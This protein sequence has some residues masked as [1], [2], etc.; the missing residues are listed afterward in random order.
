[1]EIQSLRS[2]QTMNI[3]NSKATNQQNVTRRMNSQ[4]NR[5]S[6]F[7]N[8][9]SSQGGFSLNHNSNFAASMKN[10]VGQNSNNSGTKPTMKGI[11]HSKIRII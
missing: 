9:A 1:M 2:A 3:M 8:H 4:E 7:L 11:K 6:Q 5:Q 10:L